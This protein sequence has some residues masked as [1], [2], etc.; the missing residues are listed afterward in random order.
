MGV[1]DGEGDEVH[2]GEI[3]LRRLVVPST[4]SLSSSRANGTMLK[5]LPMCLATL[6]ANLSR[7][8]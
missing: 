4:S 5:S 6:V 8:R 3:E 1:G 7:A 2:E